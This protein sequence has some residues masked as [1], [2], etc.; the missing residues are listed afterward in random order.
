MELLVPSAFGL[1]AVVKRQLD[2]LGYPDTKAINGRISV[3]GDWTDVARLN[4]FLATGERVLIKLTEFDVK[5]FDDIYDNIFAFNW[6]DFLPV[7]ARILVYGKSV[8]SVVFAVKS[9]ISVMKKAIVDKLGKVY[10]SSLD[11]SGE[12]YMIELSVYKDR[13]TVTLDT[14]GDGLFKRGYRTLAYTAPLKETTAA[15]LL[16]LSVYNPDKKFVDLFC[17]SGTLPIETALR[18]LKIAPGKRRDFDYKHWQITPSGVYEQALSEALSNETPD[19][20]IDVTGY[21]ID[22]N[23]ISISR[24][25]ARNAGVADKIRFEVADMKD[26]TCEQSYGVMI[27]NPPYGERLEDK[28]AVTELYKKLGQVYRRL[29][30]WNFYVLTSMP[31]FERIFGRNCD[32]NRKIYNANIQCH[33]YSFMGAKPPKG[34]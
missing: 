28:D 25:H 11:E 14:S 21:D 20:K 27:C 18:A 23:A 15:A 9:S 19:R 2:R 13:A 4:M 31:Y 33:Y 32:K 26:F 3:N 7:N 8:E 17:G 10:R 6:Q 1:E 24:Y 34:N 12:R 5:S 16:D 22:K 30:D 29:P